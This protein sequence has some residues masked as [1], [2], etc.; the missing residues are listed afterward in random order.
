MSERRRIFGTSGPL[1]AEPS[2]IALVEE[3]NVTPEE[4]AE[5]RAELRR[6]EKVPAEPLLPSGRLAP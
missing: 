4:R 1:G 3:A 6:S 5:R 2:Q